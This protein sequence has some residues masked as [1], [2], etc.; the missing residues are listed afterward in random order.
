[1]ITFGKEGE[2][3]LEK[4]LKQLHMK[5]VIEPINPEKMTYAMKKEA[6]NYLMYLTEKRNG[7]IKGRGCADGRKQRVYTTKEETSSPTVTTEAIMLTAGIDAKERR[8]VA[9]SDIP[10]AFL[11]ADMEGPDVYV[12]LVGEIAELLLKMF[13]DEYEMYVTYEKGKMVIYARLKK[14]LYGT[15]QAALLFWKDL[16]RQL[17]SS[18]IRNHMRVVTL[19][20]R[21]L[22][23]IFTIFNCNV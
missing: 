15:M 1:M 16:S 20:L 9:T 14:A 2:K 22:T 6:L 8:D 19:R 17:L 4:E 7:D 5:D 21:F 10:G 13:L 11:Q 23:K 3:A 12:K 18:S